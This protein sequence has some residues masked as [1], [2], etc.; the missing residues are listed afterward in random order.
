MT[1]KEKITFTT[2]QKLEYAK[3]MIDEHYTNQQIMD[4][5]G[6]SK[7]AVSR[8]R[9]QY[10]Q[11]LDGV[12]PEGKSALTPEQQRI[13][14]LEKQLKRAQRDNEILKKATAFFVRDNHNLN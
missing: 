3:L 6:A 14:E 1:R 12:T 11:E 13:Q 7:S 9:Q 2:E 10:K 5:S 8:W 4:I